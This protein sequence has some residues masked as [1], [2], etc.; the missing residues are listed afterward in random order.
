MSQRTSI[1]LDAASEEEHRLYPDSDG[2]PMSDSTQQFRWIVTLQGGLDAMFRDDPSV[3]VAG[4]LL[5]YPVE[6]QPK[7]CMAPDTMV[8]FGRPRGDRRSYRQWREAGVGPQ[9]VFEVLSHTNTPA[10]MKKK[11]QFYETYGV[12][13]YY[14]YDPDHFTFIAYWRDEKNQLALVA[15][16]SGLTSPRLGIRFEH[17]RELVVYRPD[18]ERFQ[19]YSELAETAHQAQE[20]ALDEKSRADQAEERAAKER[21]AAEKARQ[22]SAVLESELEA[23]RSKLRAMGIDLEGV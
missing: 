11:L 13:E 9:V 22:K 6:G 19:T 21:R 23:L 18:G 7:I 14:I 12:E 2:K 10:E 4:D 1:Y 8:V 17:D 20:R 3:F 15:I 5:W 16:E